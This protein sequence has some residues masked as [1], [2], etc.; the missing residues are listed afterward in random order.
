MIDDEVDGPGADQ[1]NEANH[2]EDGGAYHD[3]R[4]PIFPAMFRARL[5][6]AAVLDVVASEDQSAP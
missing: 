4:T 3:N 6:D 5:F 2:G 1:D